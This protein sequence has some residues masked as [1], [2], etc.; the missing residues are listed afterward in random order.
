M[1]GLRSKQIEIKCDKNGQRRGGKRPGA[2]RPKS[3]VRASERHKQRPKFS[4]YEPIHVVMRAR[5]E[6]GSLRTHAVFRAIKEASFTAFA[7]DERALASPNVS[8]KSRKLD[9][10]FHIVHLSIQRTHVHMIVEA[11]DRDALFRGM[12]AFGISAARHI[13]GELGRKGSVF[14]DRY[15]PRALTTPTQVRNCLAYVLNNWKHH[16]ESTRSLRSSWVVDPYSTGSEFDGWKESGG[17]KLIVASG[18]DGPM[19]WWAKTWLLREGWRKRGLIST[20]FVPGGD[21]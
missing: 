2:G 15:F 21:E 4:A 10:A 7:H 12:Q 16:K 8:A 20:D 1:V 13:N 6:V 19:V 14:A 5:P 11:T 9:R 3:G 18:H 17:Q